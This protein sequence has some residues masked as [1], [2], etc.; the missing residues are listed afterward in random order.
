MEAR[1]DMGKSHLPKPGSILGAPLGA[2]GAGPRKYNNIYN[3]MEGKLQYKRKSE[4]TFTMKGNSKPN[5]KENR[6]GNIT[7]DWN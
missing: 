4:G 1:K 5:I 2:R 7:G 3:I 6:K